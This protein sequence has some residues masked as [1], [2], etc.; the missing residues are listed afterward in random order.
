VVVNR[1]PRT[2][3]LALAAAVRLCMGFIAFATAGCED[4]P[5]HCASNLLFWVVAS[6]GGFLNAG[7]TFTGP[8]GSGSLE[9]EES[10]C[11]WSGRDDATPGS[12]TL[13]VTAL[14]YESAQ[15]SATIT[16]TSGCCAGPELQPHFV[17]LDPLPDS[18]R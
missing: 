9:C 12:Y 15:V 4:C 13:D 17:T 6:D 2:A 16:E 7:V 5:V 14:G 10:P 8:Q 1:F 18:G 3:P 11:L